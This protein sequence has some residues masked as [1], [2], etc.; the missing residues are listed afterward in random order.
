MSFETRFCPNCGS[1]KVEPDTRHT[2]VLGEMIFNPD[3]W[4]C[5]ECDYTGLMPTDE[6]TEEGDLPEEE[7]IRFEPSKNEKIDTDA[8]KAYTKFYLILI[9]LGLVYAMILLLK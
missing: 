6:D 9:I 5:R 7:E 2:N 8:G 3:K 1:R 4:Y